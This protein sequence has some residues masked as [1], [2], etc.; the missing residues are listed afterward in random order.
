MNDPADYVSGCPVEEWDG[1]YQYQCG[2][3]ATVLECHRHGPFVPALYC[4][5]DRGCRRPDG[6]GGSCVPRLR[7]EPLDP[8]WRL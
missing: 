7:P 8:R 3:G 2:M 5:V 6:H 4:Q 1:P